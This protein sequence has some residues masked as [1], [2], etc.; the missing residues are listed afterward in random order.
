MRYK[1]K[2][3]GVNNDRL[4]HEKYDLGIGYK[5]KKVNQSFVTKTLVKKLKVSNQRGSEV[6]GV[7]GHTS[8]RSMTDYEESD[9]AEQ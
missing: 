1:K 7:T 2:R 3:M 9:E 4:L 8:E 5:E 6:I